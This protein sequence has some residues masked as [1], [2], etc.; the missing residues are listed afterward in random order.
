MC[1]HEWTEDVWLFCDQHVASV[2]DCC[3]VCVFEGIVASWRQKQT[4]TCTFLRKFFLLLF[5]RQTQSQLLK[6]IWSQLLRS[7]ISVADSWNYGF[8]WVWNYSGFLAQLKGHFKR[9]KDHEFMKGISPNP[10]SWYVTFI[11]SPWDRAEYSNAEISS[12]HDND[13]EIL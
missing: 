1:R 13:E 8:S 3:S 5:L 4:M 11:S 2:H 9:F 6:L 12:S 7:L 10:G